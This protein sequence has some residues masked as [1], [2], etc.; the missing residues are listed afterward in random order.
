MIADRATVRFDAGAT[1]N[2]IARRP[3]KRRSSS[4][5]YLDIPLRRSPSAVIDASRGT[6]RA[7][8]NF[9]I[10]RDTTATANATQSFMSGGLLGRLESVSVETGSGRPPE[11]QLREL[12][13]VK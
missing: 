7:P 13:A 2:A 10:K 8:L 6:G 4:R 9:H 12:A 1:E 3:S 5:P 11:S